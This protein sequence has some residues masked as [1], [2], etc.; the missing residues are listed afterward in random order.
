VVTNRLSRLETKFGMTM[1]QK[2]SIKIGRR[3][4]GIIL[5]A[6]E[7]NNMLKVFFLKWVEKITKYFLILLIYQRKLK[8]KHAQI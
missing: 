6:V 2:G 8:H 5:K 7:K 1:N 3:Y 4:T